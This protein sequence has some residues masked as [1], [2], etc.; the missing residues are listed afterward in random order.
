[1]RADLA[2]DTPGPAVWT[3]GQ[4]GSK[5]WALFISASL[6]LIVCIRFFS[7][8]LGLVPGVV[9][10]IDV[11]LTGLLILFLFLTLAR[12]GL[13]KDSLHLKLLLF[14]FY[15]ISLVSLFANS[16][17][18]E[19]L[20]SLLFL[21]GFTAPY[22]FALGVM[23][24]RFT[25]YD[26]AFVIK[27]FFWLGLLELAMGFFYGFPVF[28]A[29]GNPDFVSGTFGRNPYQFTYFIGVWFLYVLGGVAVKSDSPRRGWGLAVAL[30]AVAVFVLFYAA[31][32]RAM[33]IFFT[34]VILVTLWASPARVSS[35]VVLT[36]VVGTVSVIS[37]IV[38]GTAYPNLKLLRVFD[39]FEDTTPV[40]QSGKVE[41]VKNIVSMYSE[42]NHTAFIGSGPATFS[43]RGYTTFADNPDASKD[44]AGP[45]AVSLMGGKRYA[46]DVARRY[47]A[48][49]ADRPIQ[50][51]TT[52]SSPLSSYTSLAAE[53]GLLGLIA[54]LA[55]Y[56]AA[57]VF[58]FRS[59]RASARAGDGMGVRLGFACFGGLILLLIQAG[60]DN[61]LETTRVAIPMWILVGLLYA[62]K[63]ADGP[64]YPPGEQRRWALSRWSAR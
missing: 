28:L 14:A 38:I 6:V 12:R 46:T 48:T 13:Y 58:S 43:S 18:V 35:R 16:W 41:V 29:T 10:F 47:V 59:L 64:K 36:I 25:R 55:A 56:V 21:F 44:A 27:T 61:W 33:L 32:Y 4:T 26:I 15:A 30:A 2:L 53:V 40:V 51:G 57:L 49:I 5:P 42:M 20:P 31:Q 1:L 34:A 37:L 24:A 22:L 60:F 45:L 63:H 39:L 50:G 9:Q 7:E 23:N 8:N 62:L 3:S 52:L 54:Y 11:P 19:W 17:R